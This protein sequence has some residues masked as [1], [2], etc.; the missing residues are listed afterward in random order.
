M[1]IA[2]LTHYDLDGVVSHIILLNL[3]PDKVHY[4]S[5]GYGKLSDKI[6]KIYN[7]KRLFNLDILMITD[8]VVDVKYIKQL[9]KLYDNIFY[10]D[11]HESS[12][13]IKEELEKYIKNIAIDINKCGAQIVFD[14][15]EKQIIRLVPKNYESLKKLVHYTNI[16]D[17]WKVDNKDFSTSYYLSQLFFMLGWEKFVERYKDGMVPFKS[18][19]VALIK[20][21]LQRKKN[22]LK[23][24]E[25]IEFG[26]KAILITSNDGNE[27]INEST[28]I[29]KQYE[30]YFIFIP[31]FNKVSIR[32]RNIETNL[33]NIFKKLEGNDKIQNIG[34]HAHAGGFVLNPNYSKEDFE[35]II[36]FIYQ[37]IKK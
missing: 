29:Y 32:V 13:L 16:Y 36:N 21:E 8:L 19:E 10:F 33:G 31:K 27:I 2:N 9:A 4:Y 34:G 5:C 6:E 1:S 20:Q 12:L 3:F 7:E 17:T 26:N 23:T 22:I 35:N 15:F 28:L 11:H 37:E 14:V 25:K 30:I 18:D 24:A